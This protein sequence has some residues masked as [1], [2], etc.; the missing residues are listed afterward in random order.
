MNTSRQV[1]KL[2]TFGWVGSVKVMKGMT[3]QCAW[4][5]RATEGV[6]S[7]LGAKDGRSIIRTNDSLQGLRGNINK[8]D[9]VCKY[10]VKLT[11]FTF[12]CD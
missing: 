8:D 5:L 9:I 3:W 12:S 7:E 10:K 1:Y 6:N 4:R 11:S 2:I